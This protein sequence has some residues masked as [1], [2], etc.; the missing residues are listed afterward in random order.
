MISIIVALGA[1]RIGNA[2]A[3]KMPLPAPAWFAETFTFDYAGP[4][5]AAQQ[6]DAW[7][8]HRGAK[9]TL[10]WKEV[11]RE[12][13]YRFQGAEYLNV[14]RTY[15]DEALKSNA[16]D[17]ASPAFSKARASLAASPVLEAMPNV[18]SVWYRLMRFRAEL[19]ATER[20]LQLRAGEK[21]TMNS[22]CSD[23]TWQLTPNGMKFSRAI[24]VTGPQIKFPLTYTR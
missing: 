7:V 5:A 24:D 15:V 9:R 6:T 12:I 14:M 1:S 10:P 22:R 8:I 20:V 13:D 23:G 19:E 4:M 17:P 18:V 21:L 11:L 3:R 2:A 16:C